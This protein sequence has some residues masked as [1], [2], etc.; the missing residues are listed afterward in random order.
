MVIGLGTTHAAE[1]FFRPI[2]ASAVQAVGLGVIDPLHFELGVKA[3]P[4]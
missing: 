4:R 1:V 2:G 3:V